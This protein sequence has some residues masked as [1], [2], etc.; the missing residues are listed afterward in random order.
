M[1]VSGFE[2][3]E[4]ELKSTVY[5]VTYLM[6]KQEQESSLQLLAVFFI[7]ACQLLSLVFHAKINFPW[8]GYMVETAFKN[9]FKTFQIVYWLEHAS[10]TV[11]LIV[12]YI[13][14]GIV[15]IV[16]ADIGYSSYRVSS[17]KVAIMW[18]L[19][20]LRLALEFLNTVF[21]MPVICKCS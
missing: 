3:F 2:R 17:R 6:L 11:F 8:K 20:F 13:T 16:C 12:F 18:P 5:G 9:F 7:Q 14:F 15:M 19:R 10:W 4:A 1:E 21:F